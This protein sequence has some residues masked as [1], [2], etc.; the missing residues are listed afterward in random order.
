MSLCIPWRNLANQT[1][2]QNERS[3]LVGFKRGITSNNSTSNHASTP[4][5][6]SSAAATA[7]A[8]GSID[9]DTIRL[10]NPL[11]GIKINAGPTAI[12]SS[13]YRQF[14]ISDFEIGKSWEKASLVRFIASRTKQLGTFVP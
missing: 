8:R 11:S 14:S 5:A 7:R 3:S 2:S 4:V 9:P 1:A 13:P 10:S 6:S 12:D